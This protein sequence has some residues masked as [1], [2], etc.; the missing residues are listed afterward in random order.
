[1]KQK[2]VKT[3]VELDTKTYNFLKL[4][5]KETDTTIEQVARIIIWQMM[6]EE[7]NKLK[8]KKK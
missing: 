3:T 6:H 1:M 8:G 5:A 7:K 2:F 4:V